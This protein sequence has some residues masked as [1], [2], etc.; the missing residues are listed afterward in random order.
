LVISLRDEDGVYEE[1]MNEI[2]SY[3]WND[4]V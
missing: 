2:G 4:S 1:R 3:Y